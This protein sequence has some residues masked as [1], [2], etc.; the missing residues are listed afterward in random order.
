MVL[1]DLHVTIMHEMWAK[2]VQVSDSLGHPGQSCTQ[3]QHLAHLFAVTAFAIFIVKLA[4]MVALYSLS[5]RNF[6]SLTAYYRFFL[7]LYTFYLPPIFLIL[8]LNGTEE[9]C[10]KHFDIIIL[11]LLTLLQYLQLIGVK[12]KLNLIESNRVKK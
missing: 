5:Q 1:N 4:M 2:W 3:V 8:I 7:L 9:Q 10:A 6:F 12:S 11:L